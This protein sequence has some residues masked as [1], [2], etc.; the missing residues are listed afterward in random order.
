MFKSQVAAAALIAA[1][2]SGCNETT[3]PS[4][5]ARPVRTVTVHDRAQGEVVSLTGQVR[6]KDQ[7]SWP[8]AS[9]G[10]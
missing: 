3:Q 10:G 7:T 6:A 5:E 1:A 2:I 9:T 4:T 8:F